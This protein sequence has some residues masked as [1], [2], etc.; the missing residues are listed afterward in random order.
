MSE[1]RIV[2][3][4]PPKCGGTSVRAFLSGEDLVAERVDNHEHDPWDSDHIAGSGLPALGLIRS[5]W[6]WY[7]SLIA[8]WRMSPGGRH[9]LAPFEAAVG[10]SGA[11]V[12]DLIEAM[13]EPWRLGVRPVR[14]GPHL[15]PSTEMFH[16]DGSRLSLWAWNVARAYLPVRW[17]PRLKPD[18]V[19]AMFRAGAARV[20][21]WLDCAG[22]HRGLPEALIAILGPEEAA[23]IIARWRAF[24]RLNVT[25]GGAHAANI[26]R[27]G[28]AAVQAV[29]RADGE[30]AAALG[31]PS[32]LH[33]MPGGWRF[34]PE[35]RR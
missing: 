7:C 13:A 32:V 3:V 30:I 12:A 34:G 22:L 10:G 19:A 6:R 29:R 27:S 11:P 18:E 2:L 20:A 31:Y 23:P 4:H 33:P 15:W 5:P 25:G 35:A 26:A 8:Y 17:R 1:P 14:I 28:H 16:P 24:P 9:Q 21:V